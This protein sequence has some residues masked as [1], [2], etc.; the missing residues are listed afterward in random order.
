V[1]LVK[2]E[3]NTQSRENDKEIAQSIK[4]MH[5]YQIAFVLEIKQSGF[6]LNEV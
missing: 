3:W 6:E 5:G 2:C 4:A 1:I